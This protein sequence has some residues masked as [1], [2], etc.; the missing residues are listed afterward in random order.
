V[1]LP[2]DLRHLN[3]GVDIGG[4]AVEGS[5]SIRTGKTALQEEDAIKSQRDGFQR[6]E[7]TAGTSAAPETAARPK[8]VRLGRAHVGI[9]AEHA[10]AAN[11]RFE[12]GNTCQ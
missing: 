12:P 1:A 3:M 5:E 9:V 8:F 2:R 10:I 4:Q 6:A 7:R 11:A